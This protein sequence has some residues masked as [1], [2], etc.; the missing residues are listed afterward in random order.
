M[1]SLIWWSPRFRCRCGTPSGSCL[2]ACPLPRVSRLLQSLQE[3]DHQFHLGLTCWRTALTLADLHIL[4]YCSHFPHLLRNGLLIVKSFDSTTATLVG[5]VFGDFFLK[6]QYSPDDPTMIVAEN[7]PVVSFP[8][9]C[10]GVKLYCYF[11]GRRDYCR[12]DFCLYWP[13]TGSMFIIIHFLWLLLLFTVF[14]KVLKGACMQV[15]SHSTG[16]WWILPV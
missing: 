16:G 11:L 13:I 2:V 1:S 6:K 14:Q 8:W 9:F 12:V 3:R 7:Q 4:W 10:I 15:S 5:G